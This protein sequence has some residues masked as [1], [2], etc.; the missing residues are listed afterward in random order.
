MNVAQ[1]PIHASAIEQLWEPSVNASEHRET[2]GYRHYN[3][4]LGYYKVG[5]V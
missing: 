3:V 5:I 2:K 1:S 4:E